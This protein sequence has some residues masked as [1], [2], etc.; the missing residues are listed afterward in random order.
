MSQTIWLLSLLAVAH[1]KQC[2]DLRDVYGQEGCCE[3]PTHEVYPLDLYSDKFQGLAS[4]YANLF[5]TDMQP[6]F[7][8]LAD[9]STL[10]AFRFMVRANDK[11]ATARVWSKAAHVSRKE[12]NSIL[13]DMYVSGDWFCNVEAYLGSDTEHDK[14]LQIYFPELGPTLDGSTMS[15]VSIAPLNSV[16]LQN[17]QG[18]TM[19]PLND[20]NGQPY[21]WVRASW[22]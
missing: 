6:D 7:G 20:A 2:V 15:K 19:C 21:N 5:T 13:Y 11:D 10:V 9:D 16:D 3:M 1:A 17:V 18:G 8:K 12:E 22:I 14:T 4:T